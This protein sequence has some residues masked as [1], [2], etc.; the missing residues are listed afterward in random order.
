M[1]IRVICGSVG[2]HPR[3]PAEH[4][5]TT[6]GASNRANLGINKYRSPLKSKS[7]SEPKKTNQPKPSHPIFLVQQFQQFL[8][9]D[10]VNNQAELTKI[11]C[12]T[13][14][15]V[16]QL[17]NLLRLPLEVR[18]QIVQM[19]PHEQEYFS[20]KKLREIKATVCFKTPGGFRKVEIQ[21]LW[22]TKR[23]LNINISTK[24]GKK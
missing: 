5:R 17:M 23:K 21:I 3:L 11:D 9:S 4:R 20:G 10:K 1:S 7:L 16:T 24:I 19:P 2:V 22:L 6:P 8:R 18:T 12:I 15:R 14:A 13:R